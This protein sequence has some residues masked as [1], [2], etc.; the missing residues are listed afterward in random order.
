M[1]LIA[2]SSEKNQTTNFWCNENNAHSGS[3][4]LSKAHLTV[5]MEHIYAKRKQRHPGL[6]VFIEHICM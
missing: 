4:K 2:Y 1:E 6:I 5:F 3:Y